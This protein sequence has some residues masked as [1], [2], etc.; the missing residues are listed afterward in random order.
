M[1]SF[2]QEETTCSD[3]TPVVI[4]DCIFFKTEVHN[5]F[6]DV[7]WGCEFQARIE[8]RLNIQDRVIDAFECCRELVYGGDVHA[9]VLTEPRT[10]KDTSGIDFRSP[11]VPCLIHDSILI[12][13]VLASTTDT[14]CFKW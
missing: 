12:R 3:E 2:V 13:C 5:A 8:Q 10:I 7:K 6:R 11:L 14:Q 4:D 1:L 9:S